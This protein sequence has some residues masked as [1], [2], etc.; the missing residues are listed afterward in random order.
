MAP[1]LRC[2][3]CREGKGEREW[4]IALILWLSMY[5]CIKYKILLLTFK[6]LYGLAHAPSYITEMLQPY[7]P[8]RSLRSASMRLLT[9]PSA[10][11]IICCRSFSFTAPTIWNSL[12]EPIRNHDDVSKLITSINTFL[13]KEHFN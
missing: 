1:T 12:P 4:W 11:E 10:K 5:S 9:I 6:A 8:S 13:F 2:I 3:S 7:R